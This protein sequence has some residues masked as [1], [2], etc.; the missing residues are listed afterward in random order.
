MRAFHAV[1]ALFVLSVLAPPSVQAFPFINGG[2]ESGAYGGGPFATLSAVNGDIP[3]WTVSSG[4]V[5]WIKGY[6]A[7]AE[8]LMSLDLNGVEAGAV[9]QTF[10]TVAGRE[11]TVAFKLSGN[12]DQ[13]YAKTL[14]ASAAGYAG[15]FVYDHPAAGMQWVAQSFRFTALGNHT[16]LMFSGM[17]DGRAWGPALDDV[18]V[19]AVV[20][21]PGTLAL[22]GLGLAGL[23][24]STRKSSKA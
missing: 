18:S 7:P 21:E 11:Y 2:F 24:I 22:L 12:P 9:A 6:W 1:V 13:S 5:D 4:S 17:P 10:D 3:G 8:G 23:A 19:A 20:P 15:S 14:Y 16:T